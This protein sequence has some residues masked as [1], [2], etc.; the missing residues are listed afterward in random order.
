MVDDYKKKV[1]PIKL[2]A[3]D[4]LQKYANGER[5]FRN[6]SLRNADIKNAN[7]RGADFRGSDLSSSYFYNVDF[8]G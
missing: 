6:I 3:D 1:K 2:T 5:N 8:K 4:L 7:L